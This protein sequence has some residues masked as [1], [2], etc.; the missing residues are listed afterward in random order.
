MLTVQGIFGALGLT[1]LPA[2][3]GKLDKALPT[4]KL[5][6]SMSKISGIM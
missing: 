5:N 2:S 3:R 6:F 1:S 4:A